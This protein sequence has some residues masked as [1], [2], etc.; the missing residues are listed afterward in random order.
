MLQSVN[1]SGGKTRTQVEVHMP[2]VVSSSRRSIG[3]LSHTERMYPDADLATYTHTVCER[4]QCERTQCERTS[5]FAQCVRTGD[6]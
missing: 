4:T 2:L 6:L 5:V 1:G 3:I